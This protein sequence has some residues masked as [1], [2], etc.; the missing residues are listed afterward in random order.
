LIAK[1][2]RSVDTAGM[3]PL[4]VDIEEHAQ[5]HA[6]VLRVRGEVR[7]DSRPLESAFMRATAGRPKVA[8][9]DMTAMTF[10][11]S[12]GMGSI[13]RLRNALKLHGGKLIAC[14]ARP[15]IWDAF[16]RMRMDELFAGACG[17]VEEGLGM[18]G[19]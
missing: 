12:L 13:V 3:E 4:A 15:E 6:I 19:S 10:I 8:V 18:A 16:K 14:G 7:L 5:Q 1:I 2:A 9:L 11:S 17:T